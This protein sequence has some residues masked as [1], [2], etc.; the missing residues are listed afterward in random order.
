MERCHLLGNI[1]L[2]TRAGILPCELC[3]I[4]AFLIFFSSVAL[5]V[6]QLCVDSLNYFLHLVWSIHYA[7]CTLLAL[8]SLQL[9]AQSIEFEA[10]GADWQPDVSWR[11][12]FYFVH[13]LALHKCGAHFFL[14]F[15][16]F[17]VQ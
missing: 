17:S 9:T 12:C 10:L 6:Q 15:K 3:L 4:F 11:D 16:L 7:I 14:L 5:F 2:R 13:I 1:I 8:V